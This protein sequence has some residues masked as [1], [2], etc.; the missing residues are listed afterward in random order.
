MTVVAAGSGGGSLV[1]ARRQRRWRQRDRQWQSAVQWR[2]NTSS[3][4][5]AR[6]ILCSNI[7]R[8]ATTTVMTMSNVDDKAL[9]ASARQFH[10][11]SCNSDNDNDYGRRQTTSVRR[12]GTRPHVRE[13]N[14][15]TLRCAVGRRQSLRV[16]GRSLLINNETRGDKVNN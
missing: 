15:F 7:V 2:R 1:A 5:S 8:R 11:A 13:H 14:I 10:I 3:C 6:A 4:G 9:C 12:R 16:L